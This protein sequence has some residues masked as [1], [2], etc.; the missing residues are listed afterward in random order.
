[1]DKPHRKIETVIK[2]GADDNASLIGALTNL[3]F[4]AQTDRFPALSSVNAGYSWTWD[5]STKI[6][7]TQTHEGWKKELNEYLESLKRPAPALLNPH[8]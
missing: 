5:I 8:A 6:D 3:L 7:E 2:I 4:Q 1:M